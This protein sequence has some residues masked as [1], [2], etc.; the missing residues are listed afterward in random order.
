MK[1]SY[2][3]HAL[4]DERQLRVV[5]RGLP[6]EID[7]KSIFDDLQRQKYPIREVHRMYHPKTKAPYNMV[8]LILDLSSEGKEIY[9]LRTV[10]H[11]S[12]LSVE[13]P[14]NRGVPGQCHRCQL[15]GHSARNCYAR[16]RCVKCLG[17]HGTA[18]CSRK[19]PDPNVP[20]SCVLCPTQGH[21][22]NYRGCPRAPH[23][24]SKGNPI[25]RNVASRQ[26]PPKPQDTVPVPPVPVPQAP[27]AN[28]APVKAHN[29]APQAKPKASEP[30]KAPQANTP[31]GAW[32]RPLQSLHRP[33]VAGTNDSMKSHL[34]SM[35][36]YL[37][38]VRFQLDSMAGFIQNS[39]NNMP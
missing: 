1:V 8:L 17:D 32:S 12:G 20:P 2:H 39:L 11:L 25:G 38:S 18:D 3:T 23:R 13:A 29:S 7:N 14:R 6:K 35:K 5:V 16:P 33:A 15:Y 37:D 22:A 28:I 4:E 24:P 31:L 9:N 30:P 34:L 27:Q 10:C 36:A 19:E 21:P 26:P